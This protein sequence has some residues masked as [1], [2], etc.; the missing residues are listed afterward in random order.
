M[1]QTRYMHSIYMI[2]YT[3][4]PRKPRESMGSKEEQEDWLEERNQI[5]NNY[6]K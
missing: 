1:P 2:A 5:I 4:D 6:S 3:M